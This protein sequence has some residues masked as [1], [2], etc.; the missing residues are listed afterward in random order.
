MH[1]GAVL[2]GI[3]GWRNGADYLRGMVAADLYSEWPLIAPTL[4]GDGPH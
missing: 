4:P 2:A 1:T 3:S